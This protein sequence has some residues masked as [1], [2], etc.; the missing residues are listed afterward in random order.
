MQSKYRYYPHKCALQVPLFLPWTFLIATVIILVLG[1]V[2][3]ASDTFI[4]VIMILVGIPV[5]LVLVGV[6]QKPDCSVQLNSQ[7]RNVTRII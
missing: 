7:L 4:A 1:V 3:A 6:K 2:Y 5:Y